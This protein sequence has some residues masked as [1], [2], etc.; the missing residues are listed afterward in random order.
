MGT[1]DA[2]Y[3]MISGGV[4]PGG[5]CRSTVCEMAVTCAVA[6]SMRV[7]GWKNTFTMPKPTMVWLS[8]CSMPL[9]V[10]E[11]VRSKFV[12]MRRSTSSAGSP[13]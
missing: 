9:T 13:G 12:V 5:N 3:C 10:V 6:A 2:L 11:S 7:P 8:M 1:F 4:M